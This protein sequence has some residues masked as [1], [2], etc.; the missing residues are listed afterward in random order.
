MMASFWLS[1]VVLLLALCLAPE[2]GAA[3]KPGGG[4]DKLA[5]ITELAAKATNNVI[6]LDDDTYDYFAMNKPNPYSLIVFMTAAHPKFKCSVCKAHDTEFQLLASSYKA[7]AQAEGKKQSLFFVRLDYE[8][9]QKTFQKY[10]TNSVP[11]IFHLGGVGSD[12]VAEGSGGKD[13]HILLRDRFQSGGDILAESM[14]PFLRARAG[15]SVTIK[16][17]QLGMYVFI[18][19]L[20]AGVAACVRPVINSLD[21][22]VLPLLRYTP[23]WA[24]V[25]LGVYTCAISGL[26]F[27]IIRNPPPYHADPRTGHIMFFYPQSGSQFVIEGFVIG[28]LNLGCAVALIFLTI[29]A[30]VIKAEQTR[31]F[32]V[33]A[34]MVAFLLCFNQVKELY[35]MKN[36]WYGSSM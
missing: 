6:T 4:G 26:I 14:V 20:F 9:S 32:A 22:F 11:V 34:G 12:S 8:A 7:T 27:D 13:Y 10:D 23:A 1:C 28:F 21:T 16:R 35:R 29:K 36:R 5:Q 30:P 2:A 17:S 19:V 15:V 33:I 18:L 24:V 3:K 25:S 31:T